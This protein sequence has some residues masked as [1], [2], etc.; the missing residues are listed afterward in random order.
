MDSTF[1]LLAMKL[2]KVFMPALF[3]SIGYALAIAY[4][5]GFEALCKG[6]V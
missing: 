4:P 5:I 2:A 1:K 3:G 6:G